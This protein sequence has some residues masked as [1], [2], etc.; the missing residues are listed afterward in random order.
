[1]KP[2]E[3]YAAEFMQAAMRADRFGLESSQ[4]RIIIRKNCVE[5]ERLTPVLQ[6]FMAD[7]TMEDVADRSLEINLKLIPFLA[8]KL[9]IPFTLTIG[10]FDDHGRQVYRHD[11]KLLHDL[12]GGMK[13]NDYFK[14]LPF[15]FWLT[16]PAF[17]VLD[18]CLYTILAQV[19][20]KPEFVGGVIYYSNAETKP[21]IIYHPTITGTAFLE[22]I[23]ATVDMG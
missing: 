6:E 19:M 11:E 7:R 20:R 18:V 22:R 15:H 13:V 2:M 5:M 4:A 12:L 16:S 8:E 14:G 21:E 17:E 23:G 10:W 9:G 3:I 1:M